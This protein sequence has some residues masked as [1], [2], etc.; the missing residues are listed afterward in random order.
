MQNKAL[1]IA[2]PFILLVGAAVGVVIAL[3]RVP[4]VD[5]PLAETDRSK[6]SVTLDE[7]KA[8]PAINSTDTDPPFAMPGDFGGADPRAVTWFERAEK[9]RL[10]GRNDIAV[11]Y[12]DRALA[13]GNDVIEDR[14]ARLYFTAPNGFPFK[15]DTTE[16]LAEKLGD[17]RRRSL[18][19]LMSESYRTGDLP[20]IAQDPKQAEAWQA[21]A[22]ALAPV[23]PYA[24]LPPP[25]P[26]LYDPDTPLTVID[27]S[28]D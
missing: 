11:A 13:L 8:R 22:D 19:T 3:T 5:D 10:A 6:I 15:P 20:H 28:K 1:Y 2:A 17:S 24:D 27:D 7:S 21:K 14:V 4:M 9:K 26:S 18:Y 23:N 25:D 16:A 12:Y